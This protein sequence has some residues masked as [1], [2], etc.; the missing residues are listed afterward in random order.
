MLV[1]LSKVAIGY[2]RGFCGKKSNLKKNILKKKPFTKSFSEVLGH[3]KKNSGKIFALRIF[4][5]IIY[6]LFLFIFSFNI[7]HI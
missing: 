7:Y 1:L 6:F 2:N 5:V 3:I 4:S